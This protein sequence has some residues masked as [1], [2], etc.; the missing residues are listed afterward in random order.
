MNKYCVS[1]LFF[2]LTQGIYA[3]ADPTMPAG[4]H[5]SDEIS[6]F[7]NIHLSGIFIRDGQKT[8]II[9]DHSLHE[10]EYVEG[11][12][13][14][15]ISNNQVYIKNNNGIFIIPLVASITKSVSVNSQ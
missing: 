7:K 6:A 2:L 9:N 5:A 12:E 13:V 14:I 3:Q 8:A 1:V 4:W 10:G 11:Y 15:K